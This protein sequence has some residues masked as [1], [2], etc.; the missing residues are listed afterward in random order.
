MFLM[1]S[2][3]TMLLLS[4]SVHAFSISLLKWIRKGRRVSGLDRQAQYLRLADKADAAAKS[5]CSSPFDESADDP[6][7]YIVGAVG[8][9]YHP[10][11]AHLVLAICREGRDQ[12]G[13]EYTLRVAT[14]TLRA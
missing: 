14:H 7:G 1:E 12:P 5:R 10:E 13:L 3:A 6:L 4:D 8:V 9:P 11:D 2:V